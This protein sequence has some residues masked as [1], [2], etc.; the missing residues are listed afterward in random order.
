M[1]C[2]SAIYNCYQIGANPV[3]IAASNTSGACVGKLVSPQNIAIATTAAGL[4][5]REGE[6]LLTTFKYVTGFVVGLGIITYA[7]A[8]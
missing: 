4:V 1:L 6:I 2:H 7:F 3:W 5:G 8:F